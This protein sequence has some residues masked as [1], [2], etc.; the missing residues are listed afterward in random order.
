MFLITSQGSV[1]PG[2]EKKTWHPVGVCGLTDID[3]I[4][5]RAEF[6]LYVAPEQHRKGLGHRALNLLFAEGFGTLNL[7]LIWGETF[8]GNPAA[9]MFL[10]AGMKKEGTRREF[11]YRNG[12]YTD[13]ILYSI[14]RDEFYS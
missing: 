12:I 1:A 11:Y 2:S 3:W 14:R 8:K 5:R 4:N 9:I 7:N 13:A 10:K 6:S